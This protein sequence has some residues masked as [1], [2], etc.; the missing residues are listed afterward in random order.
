MTGLIRFYVACSLGALIN[1][2]FASLLMRRGMPWLLAGVSGT[3][4]SSVW[5]YGVNTV[6]TW[7]RS[8][9]D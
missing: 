2:A 9:R 4:I 6:L 3:A 7:R 5:N 1:V 8:T